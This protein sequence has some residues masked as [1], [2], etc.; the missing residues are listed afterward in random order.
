[1][2]TFTYTAL[3][4]DGKIEA[5]ELDAADEL[6]AGHQLKEKG[7]VP[8]ML[9]SKT[10]KSV[11]S[12]F[13]GIGRVSLQDKIVFIQNLGIMIKAGVSAP[14]ALRII[15]HQ[16]HNKKFQTC[17]ADISNMVEA[18]KSLGEAL[19]KYPDIFSNIFLSMIKVG[20][21]SGNLDESLK[22]LSIQLQREHELKSK[23]KGAMMY[24]TIIV[25]AMVI[26]GILLATFV[27]P[28]LTVSL[29]EMGGDLPY[30]T[31][32]VIGISDFFSTHYFIV[33]G[34]LI[35]LVAGIT[36]LFRTPSG[37]KGLDW[38]LLHMFLINPVTKKINLARM[39]RIL[40]SL[41]KSGTPIVEGLK[42]TADS[43]DNYYYR[44]TLAFATSEV[45]LGKPITE[46]MS[47]YEDLYPYIVVQMLQV[48]EDTGTLE[49]ILEQLAG[50]YEE[51]VD[52]TMR[53]L[54]SI[55]EP[56][57][58]LVIGGIVAFLAVALISP[59]YN[60]GSNVK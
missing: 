33:A 50:H 59:I 21:L 35:A 26:I 36:G 55:I 41:L 56:L 1:M 57:L 15:T 38:F 37:K 16:T 8:T 43:M 13:S 18:G 34:V 52:D 17:L 11:L 25:V 45:K 2:P 12:F 20:E 48:G 9:K 58:L 24:P 49:N 31:Q 30:M 46:T 39:A 29:K 54:S 19:E 32:L 5:G 27:L 23:V 53:N 60:M 14:K 51:E 6:A 3:S 47:K 4:R 28:K 7:L 40:S 44:S 10:R 42:V 22:Y